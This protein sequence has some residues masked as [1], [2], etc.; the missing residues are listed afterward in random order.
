MSALVAGDSVRFRRSYLRST[1]QVAGPEGLSRWIVQSCDCGLCRLGGH[2]AT[3]E[4]SHFY[5][6]ET[7]RHLAVSNIEKIRR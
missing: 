3:N 2:V 6:D 4:V 5:D 7:P 1:G